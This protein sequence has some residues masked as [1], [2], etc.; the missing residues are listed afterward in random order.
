MTTW[1]SIKLE[2]YIEEAGERIMPRNFPAT[3]F[4]VLGVNNQTGVFLN[5]IKSGSEINQAYLIVRGGD[6]AYNPY[7]INVGSVGIVPKE[8]DGKIISS[9]YVVFRCKNSL[10]SSYLVSVLKTDTF[11]KTID[12]VA[13]GSIRNTLSFNLLERVKI[14]IPSIETQEQIV[15]RIDAL[16]GAQELNCELIKKT[17]ELLQ[18]LIYKELNPLAKE[19]QVKKL[20]EICEINPSKVETSKLPEETKVGFLAMADV[21]EDAAVANWQDR[22]LGDV[23]SGFSFFK[24]GDVLVAKITPC[25]ENGKGAIID[26][27]KYDFGFGSTEFHVLRANPRFLLNQ[28]LYYI[29]SSKEF[30]K[31]GVRFMTGSAGQQRIPARYFQT[32]K[33]TLPELRIQKDIVSKLLVV[34]NY[35][36]QLLLQEEKLNELFDSALLEAL[37]GRLVKDVAVSSPARANI[38]PVWQAIGAVLQKLERGEMVIAKLLY[39]AQEIYRVPLGFSFT[40]QNFGPYDIQIKKVIAAG[41]SSR[42]GFFQQKNGVYGLGINAEKLFKYNSKILNNMSVV[43]NDLM[44]AIK[45]S[46]S[47]QIECL[48]TV[49]KV[50]QDVKSDDFALVNDKVQSWKPKKFSKAEVE[51]TFKFIKSKGWIEKLI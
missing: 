40:S 29:V 22:R 7:R 14:P 50:I 18:S 47:A 46:T 44:P 23:K 6:V 26:N 24:N 41:A 34:Q 4:E 15:K 21:S 39:L 32:F 16:R 28:F 13:L 42:N 37:S 3:K 33:I 12:R 20:G 11:K 9:A 31:T 2:G 35:K 51:G 1:Q 8:F 45:N 10:L 38:F 25:F 43:L 27:M 36:K 30:R 5:E 17:D 19:W 49:C 48:A